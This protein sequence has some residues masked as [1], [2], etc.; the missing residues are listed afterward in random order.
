MAREYVFANLQGDYTTIEFVGEE[1][2][3]D[4]R[5]TP[6]YVLPQADADR[7]SEMSKKDLKRWLHEGVVIIR[8]VAAAKNKEE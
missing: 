2:A 8:N 4:H 5:V 3:L 7:L 6:G 1:G